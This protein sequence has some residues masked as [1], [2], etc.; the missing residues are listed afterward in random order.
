MWLLFLQTWLTHR[1]RV[2]LDFGRPPPAASTCRVFPGPHA[3]ADGR[4]RAAAGAA[5]VRAA[6]AVLHLPLERRHGGAALPRDH[7]VG[8][9]AEAE[10]MAFKKNPFMCTLKSNTVE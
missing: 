10:Y 1:P 5:A 7:T 4:R 3:S 6:G 8:P 2:D 9:V